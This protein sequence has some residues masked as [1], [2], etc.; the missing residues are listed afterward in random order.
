ME[1]MIGATVVVATTM[2]AMMGTVMV[3]TVAGMVGAA[4]GAAATPVKWWRV[5][6]HKA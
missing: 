6:S 1:D 4:T 5:Q 2:A 3:A